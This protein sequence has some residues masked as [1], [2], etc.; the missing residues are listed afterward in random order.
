[1][2]SPIRQALR[3]QLV[4]SALLICLLP[5]FP[6]WHQHG[7]LLTALQGGLA[8]TMAGLQNAPRWWLVIHLLFAPALYTVSQLQLS[9]GWFL[10]GFLLLLLIFWRT[11]RSQVPLF[12]SSSAVPQALLELLPA[13]PCQV[14][15]LG[16]GDGALLRQ[17]ARARPDCQFVGIEHA[18]LPWLWARLLS[19]RHPNLRI[20]LGDFWQEDLRHYALVYAFLSPA[21]MPRLW[22]Q[23]RRRLSSEALLVSNSFAVPGHPADYVLELPDRRCT[24]LHLYRPGRPA[25]HPHHNQEG[26]PQIT[27]RK[28]CI[29]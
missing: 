6:Q 25:R 24:R 26:A 17:L 28:P 13:E 3:A 16:C 14:L 15:D 10:A 20:R 21:A 4:A 7:L 11:D 1:M 22:A 12:L 29:S 18:P 19:L 5:L 27:R 8:A 9:P 2:P 23:A